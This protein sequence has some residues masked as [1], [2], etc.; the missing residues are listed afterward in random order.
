MEKKAEKLLYEFKGDNY[1][2]GERALKKV[3]KYA[4][5]LGNEIAVVSGRHLMGSKKLDTIIK[6]IENEGLKV[7]DVFEGSRPNAPREDVY[8]LAYQL[9]RLKPGGVVN[10][11]GGSTIDATKAALT[12]AT[13]GG[14][15]DN[16][17]GTG[18]VSEKSGGK[19]LPVVA[20]QTASSSGAHLTK[21]SNITDLTT[22][23][24][25]LIVDDSI[26]PR[27]SVFQY[28]TTITTPESLTK[29]GALDGIAHCWEVWMGATGKG[30]YDKASEIAY[31]GI[32]LLVENLPKVVENPENLHSRSAIGLGTD[33]GGYAIMVGGTN[34]PHLGSFS[35][36]DI[37][38]HG[39]ACAILNPYYTV[40]FGR[41]I[42]DQLRKISRIY[43]EFG[44]INKKVENLKWRELAETVAKGMMKLSKSIDF[45]LTLK[46]AG[47]TE[48]HIDRMVKAAKD[49]QLKM[50]LQN[51]PIPMDAEAG[52]VDKLMEPTLRAA[53]TGDLSLIPVWHGKTSMQS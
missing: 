41:A 29:D 22:N 25:K 31:T 4:K 12:L 15:I 5:N 51:M 45:P 10:I 26:V 19:Q 6:S 20:V 21:Y 34:G 38:S 33:L 14:V 3:G 23:Q 46:D 18:K 39:R 52:D 43:S 2:F 28:D 44:Y 53:Y 9:T 40:L 13:Y 35:L 7:L 37:L 30:Y 36:I 24:K 48:A 11:G 16:Y 50:K 8:R 27:F 47:A 17:F 32:K 49:P 1:A 42:Q